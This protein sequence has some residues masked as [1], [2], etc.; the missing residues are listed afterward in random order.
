MG[1]QRV[2]LAVSDP[3]QTLGTPLEPERRQNYRDWI[4]NVIEK[5]NI[6]LILVGMPYLA[7]GK[8][9]TQAQKTK[10]FIGE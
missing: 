7:S 5:E 1:D 8:I 2:G 9:G 6:V 10:S 3:T 4:K